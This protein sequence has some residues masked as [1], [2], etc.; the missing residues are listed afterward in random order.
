MLL[1][2][3]V[4]G[5]GLVLQGAT[6]LR[7]GHLSIGLLTVGA[8]GAISGIFLLSGLWTPITGVLAALVEIS[9]ASFSHPHDPWTYIFLGT[10]GVSLALLGPGAY[11]VDARLFGWKRIDIPERKS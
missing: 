10:L 8:L 4:G 6:V 9:A 2:R 5:V 7:D 11:S 3:L 1:L